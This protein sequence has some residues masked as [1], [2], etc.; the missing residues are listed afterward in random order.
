[1]SIYKNIIEK[2]SEKTQMYKFTKKI[3][4]TETSFVKNSK[5]KDKKIVK[6]N[7]IYI[8]INIVKC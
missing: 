4:K 7:G 6:S 2:I 3:Y 1:M 8:L 5:K